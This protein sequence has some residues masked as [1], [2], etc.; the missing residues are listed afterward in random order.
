MD[1]VELTLVENA[2]D[3]SELHCYIEAHYEY[4]KSRLASSMLRNWVKYSS[5][6]IKVM[7]IEYKK[8]IEN[9]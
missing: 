1:S 3:R 4:T 5:E 2:A 8:I 7:P 6:F 9:K